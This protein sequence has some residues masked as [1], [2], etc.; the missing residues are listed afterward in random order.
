MLTQ[1][2]EPSTNFCESV[3]TIFLTLVN[4]AVHIS[5]CQQ[6]MV[7]TDRVTRFGLSEDRKKQGLAFFQLVSLEMFENLSSWPLFK[8]RSYIVKFKKFPF[9]KSLPFFSSSTWQPWQLTQLRCVPFFFTLKH[10][11]ICI[12][13]LILPN[14]HELRC[15]PVVI[16]PFL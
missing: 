6:F 3:N 15:V 11:F 1:Q 16:V 7:A 2:N 14:Q 8:S 4:L 9:L 12:F 13:L 5:G 10:V